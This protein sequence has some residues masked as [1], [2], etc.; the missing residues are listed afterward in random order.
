MRVVA[1]LIAPALMNIAGHFPAM[2]Q[3]FATSHGPVQ[4]ETLAE[5]ID[6]PWGAAQLPDGTFLVTERRGR[7]LHVA[8]GK[9]TA[10][11]GVPQVAAT[12]Q[13][14]LLDIAAD[15]DFAQTRR[16]WFT[17]SEPGDGGQGTAL[18][19]ATVSADHTRL[20]GVEVLFSMNKKTRTGHH[21]GS[22][23][24]LA[25][26]GKLFVTTGDRGDGNR[27]QDF[28][29]HAGAVIRLNRDGTIPADNPFAD[30]KQALPEL[31]SKGHRNVQGAG[32]DVER[33]RLWTVE[34]GA[35]GGDEVNV[36]Q[37]GRNYGWPVITYGVN[38][39]GASIGVGTE[40]QGL[41]QPL[42]F[43]DP[44]IAP[45]GLDVY[46]GD[47]FPQWKGDLLVGALKFQLLVR[48]DVEGDAIV[49]EERLLE[50]E[51]GRIRDVGML[52]DGAIYLLTD[53]SEGKL[54]RIAPAK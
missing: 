11:A 24:V 26:D 40:K 28:F 51:F 41:E 12:G 36:P 17:Y 44:S 37:A 3:T 43:W 32:W 4:V 39:N 54:L 5:G 53:E 9:Q 42:H 6:H 19:T 18:A 10:L 48:L 25:P 52:A 21:F 15:E 35:R 8:N 30:G 38:Y 22:R 13:G 33:N 49:G 7:L 27:S 2:A 14:G 16:V 34:H 29:D 46:T 47:L 1:L 50:G 23:V 31:W 20:E 45:S